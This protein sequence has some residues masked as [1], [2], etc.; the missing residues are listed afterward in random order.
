MCGH[1]PSQ[2]RTHRQQ[3]RALDAIGP[4]D[5]KNTVSNV[6]HDRIHRV[7]G[8]NWSSSLRTDHH[9]GVCRRLCCCLLVCTQISW[10]WGRQRFRVVASVPVVRST[11]AGAGANRALH[12][13]LTGQSLD[14][15]APRLLEK[16]EDPARLARQARVAE[17]RR[18]R[19]LPSVVPRVRVSVRTIPNKQPTSRRQPMEYSTHHLQRRLR[20]HKV[21]LPLACAAGRHVPSRVFPTHRTLLRQRVSS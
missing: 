8:V 6:S 4:P 3:R 14:Q 13:V 7:A 12:V 17:P 11:R 2:C 9:S 18:G 20:T 15:D 10:C 5:V 1:S 16:L 19:H 21:R